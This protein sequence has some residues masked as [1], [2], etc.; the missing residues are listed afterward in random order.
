MFN[1]KAILAVFYL[2]LLIYHFNVEDISN[3]IY[4]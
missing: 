3:Y 2:Y 4:L 1:I